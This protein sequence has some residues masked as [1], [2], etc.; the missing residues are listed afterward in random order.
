M[1]VRRT[2]IR[3]QL[4]RTKRE[5]RIKENADIFAM[6]ASLFAVVYIGGH[7]IWWATR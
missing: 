4:Q 7:L 1:V 3:V 6:I 2:Q 5:E